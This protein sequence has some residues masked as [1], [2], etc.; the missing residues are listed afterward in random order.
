MSHTQIVF[1]DDDGTEWS[2]SNP[3]NLASSNW[4]KINESVIGERSGEFHITIQADFSCSLTNADGEGRGYGR[5]FT[6]TFV[7]Q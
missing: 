6:M 1:M 5:S 2:S 7:N 4:L 3:D